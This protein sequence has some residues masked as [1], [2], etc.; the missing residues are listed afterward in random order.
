MGR[1]ANL[2]SKL[3]SV[4]LRWRLTFKEYSNTTTARKND[5]VYILKTGLIYYTIIG[6]PLARTLVCACVNA[7]VQLK[8][9]NAVHKHCDYGDTLK[10][11][12]FLNFVLL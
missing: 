3:T 7:H 4:H 11:Y 9:K 12:P 10:A 8:F 5:F 2:M 6:L 1:R